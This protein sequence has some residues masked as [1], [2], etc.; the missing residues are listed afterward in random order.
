MD[1]IRTSIEKSMKRKTKAIHKNGLICAV[2]TMSFVQMGAN[3]IAPLLASISGAFPTVP[4]SGVQFLLTTPNILCVACVL[5]FAFFSGKRALRTQAAVGQALVIAA[6]I[7]AATFHRSMALLAIWA[8]M[9]GVGIGLAAPV[10]PLLIERHFDGAQRRKLYGWQN[11]AA[12]AGSMALTAL[13]G[14]LAVK[15]WHR[16]YL[17]YLLA[18]MGLAATLMYVPR[19]GSVGDRTG[20]PAFTREMPLAFLFTMLFGIVPANLAMLLPESGTMTAGMLTTLFLLGGVF[21]GLTFGRVQGKI[22][23]Q[24]IA[25]GALMLAAGAALISLHGSTV[26]IAAGCLL[27]GA[28][29]SFVMPAC[30][31][32]APRFPGKEQSVTALTIAAS[33]VGAFLTPVLTALVGQSVTG[34]FRFAAVLALMMATAAW[35]VEKKDTETK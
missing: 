26:L 12:T 13:C 20:R 32:V 23:L 6:G 17:T 18:A 33:N 19:G 35:I 22:G 30:L 1:S 10:A 3:G 15:G 16:G 34:R 29:I 28:S 24:T 11:S 25:L 21:S 5:A 8:V 27:S 31:S 14:V 7:L 4:D 2:L 9:L